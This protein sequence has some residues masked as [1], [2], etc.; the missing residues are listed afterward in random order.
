MCACTCVYVCLTRIRYEG[1]ES[2]TVMVG[3]TTSSTFSVEAE[4]KKEG[5][6]VS[7][8]VSGIRQVNG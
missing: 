8:S 6:G 2:F 1:V 5:K 7:K 4:E 3:G